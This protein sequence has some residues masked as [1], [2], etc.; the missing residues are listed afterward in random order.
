MHPRLALST[1]LTWVFTYST[2]KCSL[3]SWTTLHVACIKL[4][5]SALMLDPF[6]RAFIASV[7]SIKWIQCFSCSHG[8]VV[9]AS[10]GP[11]PSIGAIAFDTCSAHFASKHSGIFADVMRGRTR[12]HVNSHSATATC[13]E[14]SLSLTVTTRRNEEV[15]QLIKCW[16]VHQSLL[17]PA[18]HF[19]Q[20][21]IQASALVVFLPSAQ[22]CEHC[23]TAPTPLTRSH[24]SVRAMQR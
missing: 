15:S 22:R 18:E 5:R 9:R 12:G 2:H 21:R 7:L 3:R 11:M 6:I 19:Q 20:S 17:K 4:F 8:H 10:S 13:P 14:P 24:P 16:L 1:G 23:C